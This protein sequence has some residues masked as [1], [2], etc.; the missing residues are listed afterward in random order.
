VCVQP[1]VGS[2]DASEGSQPGSQRSVV[3]SLPSSQKAS[4]GTFWQVPVSESHESMVHGTPS[5]H[6]S[7]TLWHSPVVGSQESDVHRSKSSHDFA[8]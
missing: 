4:F 3:V 7:G 1:V 8:V 6:T 5:S 2:Q